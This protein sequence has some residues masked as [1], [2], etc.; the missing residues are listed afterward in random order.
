MSPSNLKH[1]ATAT[2]SGA[3]TGGDVDL[4]SPVDDNISHSTNYA[5]RLLANLNALRSN[6]NNN[7]C[8]VEIVAGGKG[9]Q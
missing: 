1:P 5:F 7:L 3:S 6:P 8:D 2:V 9:I 4:D